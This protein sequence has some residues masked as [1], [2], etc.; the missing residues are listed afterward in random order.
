MKLISKVL[1][2]LII[3]TSSA[4]IHTKPNQHKKN[5]SKYEKHYNSVKEGQCSYR[6][7]DDNCIFKIMSEGCYNKVF[8]YI[9]EYGEVDTKQRN[10]FELC[11]QNELK[12]SK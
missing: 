12:A 11:Y 7:F 9:I 6:K 1:I 5:M 4:L 3:L 8:T 2:L 10:K